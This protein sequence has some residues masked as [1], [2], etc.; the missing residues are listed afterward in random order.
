MCGF[1]RTGSLN[2]MHAYVK[3]K[4]VV[5]DILTLG[6]GLGGGAQPIAAMLCSQGIID[7][8][9]RRNESF[10]HGVTFQNLPVVAAAGYEVMNIIEEL[11]LL[12]NV[13]RLAPLLRRLLE[14][15]LASHPNVSP[16]RGEGFFLGV[17]QLDT[18][19]GACL[20]VQWEYVMDKDT[21]KPY[22][23]EL[24]I[25]YKIQ[26]M[27]KYKL[28][29][30]V[31]VNNLTCAAGMEE[32]YGVYIYPG[33]GCNGGDEGDHMLIAPP[34]NITEERIRWLV[35]RLVLL[36]NDFFAQLNAEQEKN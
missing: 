20:L 19:L 25:A 33:T 21:K 23:P 4:G 15:K 26:A 1:G 36:H 22:N 35:D 5:P 6:K 10:N 28:I 14:N 11:N 2:G 3:H 9:E 18:S 17:S 29:T 8:L 24:N 30:R 12:H 31:L 7:A 34:F 32:K 27:G 16:I 13:D